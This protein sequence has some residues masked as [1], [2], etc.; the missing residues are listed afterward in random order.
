MEIVKYDTDIGEVKAFLN[1]NG[2][3]E[4]IF[5]SSYEGKI[6]EANSVTHGD[7]FNYSID[8]PPQI[9]TKEDRFLLTLRNISDTKQAFKYKLVYKQRDNELSYYWESDGELN[10]NETKNIPDTAIF[11]AI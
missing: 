11:D 3:V 9:Q 7:S 4:W 5:R 8:S 6:N 1:V 10:P 2:L